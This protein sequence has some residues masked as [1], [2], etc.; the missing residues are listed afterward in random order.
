[1]E[2]VNKIKYT[3]YNWWIYLIIGF[4]FL[5]GSVYVFSVPAASYLSLSIF[6][7]AFMLFDGIGGISLSLT[8]REH[9]KGW[10]WQL[11]SG[12]ISLLIGI[13]LL[14]RPGLSMVMLPIF[15]GFWVLMKGSLVIG[16]SIDLK[17]HEVKNWGWILILGILNTVL[18]MAMI[19][20]P[21]FG[22]SMV[23]I[24]TGISLLSLGISMITVSLWLR[25]I[26]IKVSHLKDNEN[27]KLEE[28]KISVESYINNNPDDIQSAL[29]HIKEKVDDAMS[30]D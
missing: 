20:N 13:S 18:G 17:S 22:V 21:I 3:I 9:M 7:A 23:L 29:K 26:K 8:N 19:V 14:I 27:K 12:I 4:F 6:F 1:M 28:L 24:L 10:G 5:L 2:V 11:T 16:T 30:K 15:V 25:K